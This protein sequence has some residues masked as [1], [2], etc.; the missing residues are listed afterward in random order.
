MLQQ[1]FF[2]KE[3]IAFLKAEIDKIKPSD[4]LIVAGE[5]SYNL[6]GAKAIMGEQLSQYGL[7][8]FTDFETNPKWEDVVKGVRIIENIKPQVIIAVGGGSAIDMAKLIRFF[9]SYQ[10]EPTDKEFI[11]QKELIPLFGL[12]TTAGTGSEATRFAVCYVD[13]VKYSVEHED[14]LPDYALIYPPF[15]YNNPKYLTACTVF[16]AFSQSVE[17]FWSVNATKE[18]EKYSKEAINLLWKNMITV[19]NQPTE[20]IRD[21]VAQGSCLSGKAINIAKTTAP[22]AFSYQFTSKLGYPHGHAVALTF[23]FFFDL[24]LNARQDQLRDNIDKERYKEK[25]NTLRTLLNIEKGK[26]KQT[27]L[28]L[29]KAMGLQYVKNKENITNIEEMLFNVNFQRLNNNPVIIDKQITSSLAE[30]L[31]SL[32]WKHKKRI[33]VDG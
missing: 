30:Y 7:N 10:G 13:K 31:K 6:C 5:H 22:H 2:G 27:M 4:I 3:A 26:E 23:P 9:Y 12:P 17:S 20:K 8:F 14:I 18:S 28:N 15:T 1:T 33:L 19:V 16:D 24:N 25:I 32:Q 21:E 11:K 29:I